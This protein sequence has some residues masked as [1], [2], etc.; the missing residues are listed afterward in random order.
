MWLTV[1]FGG[2]WQ[3]IRNIFSWR[4][5][6][7]FW[8]VIWAT[9]TL[10]VVVVT[11]MLCYSFIEYYTRYDSYDY[12]EEYDTI[13]SSNFKF[14][15]NGI[16]SGKS[17]IYDARTKKKVMKDI[18]WIAVPEDGDSLIIVA[19]DGKRGFVSR[20]T[21][22]TVIPFEYDAAW[23]FTDGVA[24][25]CEGDSVYFIDH[26]GNP[27]NSKKFAREKEYDGYVY[28]GD[29]AAIPLGNK[30]GLVD[31]TGEWAVLPEYSDIHIGAKNRWYV[32]DDGKWGVIG[33]DGQFVLPVEYENV[34]IHGTNGITVAKLS[35]HSQSRYDYDG[36]L[37][38]R[39]I[40]D[41]V[42]EMAY[43]INE[44]DVDGNQKRAVDNKV[45]YSANNYYG[46]MTRNGVP[47]TPPLYSDIECL[48][49]GV[50]Q[51]R[52]S[53]GFTDCIMINGNGE[54]IND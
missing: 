31:K 28:H 11:G 40:F 17:Y 44:F 29:Y 54:K 39:F 37:L 47:V 35:D 18:D 43:Y 33:P 19:K 16:N 13:L 1:F 51:C 7:P 48:A 27:I 4:N 49:P 22:E 34:W 42:Y 46:L 24:A 20:F 52:V 14:R 12:M 9:I 50:Y 10:C 26:S 15:N 41:E 6:T 36:N 38:D 25:V 8:R 32:M 3:F 2:I 30:Y 5:K 23:S 45:K 53:D 21:A